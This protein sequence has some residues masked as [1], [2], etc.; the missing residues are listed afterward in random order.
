MAAYF[1]FSHQVIDSD[2][3]NNQYLPKAVETLKAY[4]PDILVVDQ[5]IELIEGSTDH[6]RRV[7]LKFKD[8]AEAKQWYNSPEYQ[9]IIHLRLES[10]DG[11]AVLCDE[12]DLLAI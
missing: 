1:I 7:I 5:D 12:F 11:N 2:K 3:L 9:A 8:K 6:S 4:N 10:V